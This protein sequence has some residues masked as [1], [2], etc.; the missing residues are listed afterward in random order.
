MV[1]LAGLHLVQGNDDRLEE[2]HVLVSERDCE[3]ADDAGQDVEE[4]RRAVELVGLVDEGVEGVVDG[5][6]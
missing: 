6:L 3:P 5:L 1:E 2:D 4:L